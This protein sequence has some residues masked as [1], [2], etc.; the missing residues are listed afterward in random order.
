MEKYK[1]YIFI[2]RIIY[3]IFFLYLLIIAL[4]NIGSEYSGNISYLI[5]IPFLIYFAA[6]ITLEVLVRKEIKMKK[7]DKNNLRNEEYNKGNDPTLS[8]V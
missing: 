3:V 1:K 8:K 2:S 5:V 6:M 7:R 4:S